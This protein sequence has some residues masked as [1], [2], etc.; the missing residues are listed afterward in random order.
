[1]T[2]TTCRT[3]FSGRLRAGLLSRPTRITLW[4]VFFWMCASHAFA[5]NILWENSYGGSRAEYLL[6]AIATPDQGYL[7]AGSTISNRSGD[8]QT[9]TKGDLDY[10]L[11]KMNANGEIEWQKSYGGSGM[12]LLQSVIMTPDG[13]YLLGGF[14]NSEYGFDKK[15]P[16]KGDTDFWVIKVDAAGNEQWQRTLGGSGQE[17]ISSLALT[18]DGGYL[19]G[20][21]SSSKKTPLDAQNQADPYGKSDNTRG[22]LDY[23]VVKLSASGTVVWQKTYGGKFKDELKCVLPLT[24]GDYVLGGYSNSP[25]SGDKTQD[26]IGTGDYWIV[27]IHPNGDMVWQQ[28]IGG[29]HDDSL[30]TLTATADGGF[31]VGGNSNSGSSNAKSKANTKG[32]DYWIVK[33]TPQGSIA[34]QETYNFGQSDVMR[35]IVENPDGSFLIAGYAQSEVSHTATSKTNAKPKTDKEGISDYIALR[36]SKTGEKEWVKTVGSKGN[37]VMRQLFAT[38]DGGYVLAGTSFGGKSRDKKNSKGG[39][40]F[41]IVKLKDMG[42]T[43]Q[44]PVL[45]GAMPNPVEDATKITINFGYS[46]GTATLFDLNGRQLQEFKISGE[47]EIPFSLGNL[48]SG[49]YLVNI[50]T[51]TAEESIKLIKK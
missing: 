8:I 33:M 51:N 22:N 34:W 19:L 11:W 50:K 21:S 28:T 17:K 38:R 45:I 24:G 16:C 12:D 6:D 20:G 43:E 30:T 14:S 29:D 46:Q 13:G 37:E 47:Q 27:R 5:Q 4:S 9:D 39:S 41:W 26:N 36:I 32:T 40:D 25:T 23:W 42:K 44:G 15:K 1:M 7:M 35:S 3:A 49:I 48:P 18:A 31:M 10:W 2:S